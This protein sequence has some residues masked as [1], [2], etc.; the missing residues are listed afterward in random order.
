MIPAGPATVVE[1]ARQQGAT[2]RTRGLRQLAGQHGGRVNAVLDQPH[3]G[4]GNRDKDRRRQPS[5]YCSRHQVE[6]PGLPAVLHIV[7]ERLRRPDVLESPYEANSIA[8]DTLMRRHHLRRTLGAE[9]RAAGDTPAFTTD[10]TTTSRAGGRQILVSRASG[11]FL[12]AAQVGDLV[13]GQL[14]QTTAEAL[15]LDR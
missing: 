7:D 1:W 12:P 4:S 11:A 2:L 14:L 13:L 6:V 5:R 3:P 9:Q 10:H 8:D 15:Q